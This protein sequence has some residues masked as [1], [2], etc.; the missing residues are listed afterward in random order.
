[1][2]NRLEKSKEAPCANVVQFTEDI[3]EKHDWFLHA[4]FPQ[5]RKFCRFEPNQEGLVLSLG[6]VLPNVEPI[7]AEGQFIAMRT[8]KRHPYTSFVS[9]CFAERIAEEAFHL[10]FPST[11]LNRVRVLADRRNVL[12]ARCLWF[13]D[14]F[15]IRA[16]QIDL[17]RFEEFETSVHNA[18]PAAD[19]SL[20]P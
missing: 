12:D 19:H 14:E 15:F 7:Y 11:T 3:V 10:L 16:L 5:I 9:S 8:N 1:L 17:K 2:T 4:T 18:T 13:L 20:I 6:G